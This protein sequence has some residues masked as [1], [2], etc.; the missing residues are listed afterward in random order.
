MYTLRACDDLE[1]LR[2]LHALAMP[3]DSWPGDDHTFWVARDKSGRAVGFCSAIERPSRCVFLSRAAV[4]QELKGEGLQ[5]RMIR[6]REAWARSIGAT[7]IV[8]YTRLRNYPSMINLLRCGY[9]FYEPDERWAGDV[10]YFEKSP[11]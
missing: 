9:R 4:I 8:T 10:H 6:V 1:E 5:R 3:A 7:R 2:E 11:G